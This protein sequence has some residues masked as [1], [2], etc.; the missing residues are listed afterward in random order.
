[1]TDW[2]NMAK[3]CAIS[4]GN[5]DAKEVEILQKYLFV[6]GVVDTEWIEWLIAVR[7]KV[8]EVD[9]SYDKLKVDSLKQMIQVTGQMNREIVTWILHFLKS[10]GVAA[11]SKKKHVE[12]KYGIMENK[13][14]IVQL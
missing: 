1:M 9:D 3:D 8:K 11:E 2:R 7:K 6:E 4:R 13:V 14:I 5:I 12:V 10:K